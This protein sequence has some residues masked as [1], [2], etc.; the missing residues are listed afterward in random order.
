MYLYNSIN[1]TNNNR[2][3]IITLAIFELFTPN[4]TQIYLQNLLIKF[5]FIQ[6]KVHFIKLETEYQ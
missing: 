1:N 6:F 5:S 2:K 4:Y 3:N